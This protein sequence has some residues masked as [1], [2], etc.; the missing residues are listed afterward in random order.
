VITAALAVARKDL[1][2]EWRAREIVPALAQFAVLAILIANIAFDVDR[3]GPARIAPGVLWLALAFAAITGFGRAFAAE[4]DLGTLEAMLLTPAGPT[5]IFL[6][7]TLAAL[8]LLLVCELVLVPGLAVFFA[9]PLSGYLFLAVLLATVGMSALGCLLAA[10]ASQTRARELLLP[11]LALPLWVPLVIAGGR[12]VQ[13]AL[14]GGSPL[15]DQPL[16][17]LLDFDILFV[18]TASL[19]ARFVLDD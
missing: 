5:A 11:V 8:V 2:S 1:R 7:K 13:V 12:A 16:L 6:G 3:A 14:A 15:S 17:L 18:V 4:K 19:A 10:L 9:V